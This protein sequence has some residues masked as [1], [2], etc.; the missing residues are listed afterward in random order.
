MAPTRNVAINKKKMKRLLSIDSK[1]SY[2]VQSAQL[3]AG[4]GPIPACGR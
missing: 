1:A 4:G 2:G 3:E